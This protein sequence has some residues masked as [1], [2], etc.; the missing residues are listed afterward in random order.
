LFTT[1]TPGSPSLSD[2][3]GIN[4]ELGTAFQTDIAGQIVGVRFWKTSN[5]T[6]THV[7]H[8][9]SSTGSLLA[10]VTFSNETSSGWQQQPLTAPLSIAANTTY[11]VSVNTGNAY[12]VASVG[13]L[14]SQVVN[15]DLASIAGNDGVYANP[16]QFPGS[17]SGNGANYFRDVFFAPNTTNTL[18]SLTLAPASVTGGASSV[19]TVTLQAPAPSG[20]AS[21]ALS[22]SNPLAQPHTIQAVNL[23]AGLQVD[24]IIDWSTLGASGTS[25]PSG[26]AI[27]VAGISGLTATFTNGGI[28]YDNLQ[29]KVLTECPAVDCGWSGNFTPGASVFWTNGTEMVR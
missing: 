3:P 11:V 2:G 23:A 8:I 22:A 6:G 5:E 16:G 21:V 14:S 9:W 19:G 25:V 27:P 15:Q 1:Q 26:T 10:S 20:G 7:G 24:G 12:Y 4:Y 28:P 13:G 18:A 17:P 29:F